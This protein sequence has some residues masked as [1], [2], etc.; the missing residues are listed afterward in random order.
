MLTYDFG[1]TY[2]VY[3]RNDNLMSLKELADKRVETYLFPL[4]FFFL[5]VHCPVR[6]PCCLGW[7]NALDQVLRE[8]VAGI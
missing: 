5:P 7:G 2:S 1:G 8:V 3:S 4:P 6:F